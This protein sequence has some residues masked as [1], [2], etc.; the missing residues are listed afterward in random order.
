M[1]SLDS[2]LPPKLRKKQESGHLEGYNRYNAVR[3]TAA[4]AG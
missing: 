1:Q 2:L 4:K 3:L